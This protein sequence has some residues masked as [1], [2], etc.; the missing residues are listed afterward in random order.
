MSKRL[1]GVFF[2][3][4]AALLY[5]AQYISAAIF[6][7]GVSSWNPDLFRNMLLTVGDELPTWATYSLFVGVA[8]LAWAEISK[9][10]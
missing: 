5:S 6:G 1:T 7:S 3:L 8:Y 10:K 2:C 4:I 9:E